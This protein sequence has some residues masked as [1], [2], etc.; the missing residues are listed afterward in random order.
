MRRERIRGHLD[1]LLLSVLDAGPA[2]GYE[3]VSELRRR[4]AG[5][6]DLP[7]GTVYPALYR[8]EAQGLLASDWDTAGGRRRRTYRITTAGRSALREATAEW[9]RFAAGVDALLGGAR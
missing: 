4:S 2:H 9:R 5:E 3:V 7:E 6:F 1:A 8:L